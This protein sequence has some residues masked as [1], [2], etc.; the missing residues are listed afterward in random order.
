MDYL[1][2]SFDALFRRSPL[3]SQSLQ[4]SVY[5]CV[6]EFSKNTVVCNGDE[7]RFSQCVFLCFFFLFLDVHCSISPGISLRAVNMN[8]YGCYCTIFM[9]AIVQSPNSIIRGINVA[10]LME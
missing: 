1:S 4:H 9:V 3:A 6:F 2:H 8:F 10:R 5:S 7:M